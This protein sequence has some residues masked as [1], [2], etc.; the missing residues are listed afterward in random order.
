MKRSR[1]RLDPD[2]PVVGMHVFGSVPLRTLPAPPGGVWPF[3]V[4]EVIGQLGVHRGSISRLVSVCKRPPSPAIASGAV[5]RSGQE[6]LDQRSGQ[7]AVEELA[8]PVFVVGPFE[9]GCGHEPASAALL[10]DV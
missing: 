6:L 8:D 9:V 2:R 7:W 1:R 3:P 4:T 5:P 10:D